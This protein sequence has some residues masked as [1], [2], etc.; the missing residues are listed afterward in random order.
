MTVSVA[1]SFLFFLPPARRL[2]HSRCRRRYCVCGRGCWEGIRETGGE[3]GR[4]A[5]TPLYSTAPPPPMRPRWRAPRARVSHVSSFSCLLASPVC[6][7]SAD[8]PTGRRSDPPT[9]LDVAITPR[10]SP[11]PHSSRM[12]V[13]AVGSVTLEIPPH[14]CHPRAAVCGVRRCTAP[15]AEGV[16]DWSKETA[17]AAAAGGGRAEPQRREFLIA[18][19]RPTT[20][21]LGG[22]RGK[23]VMTS[24]TKGRRRPACLSVPPQRRRCVRAAGRLPR[25]APARR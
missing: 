9:V 2:R 23:G 3:V 25:P 13:R 24:P 12:G 18:L 20:L 16:R 8:G 1:R 5:P 14:G 7:P 11:R 19:F 21:F 10:P 4:T 15:V 6:P 17:E 22:A